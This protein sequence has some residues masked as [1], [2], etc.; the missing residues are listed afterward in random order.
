MKKRL[1]FLSMLLMLVTAAMTLCLTAC[2]EKSDN[3]EP[4]SPTP[5]VP[6]G[7]KFTIAPTGGT[8][9]AGTLKMEIPSGTFTGG[10]DVYVDEVSARS[11]RGEDEV[12]QFYK[13]TMR[14][15]TGKPVKVSIACSNTDDD[16]MFV[17]RSKAYSISGG[18]TSEADM[19]LDFTYSNGVYTAEIP[20][21]HNNQDDSAMGTITFGLAHSAS[22]KPA[23]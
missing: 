3:E 7:D 9:E 13:I 20:A 17:A 8:V 22:A 18:L 19:Q 12:S 4:V 21:F 1:S 15:N 10:A 2:S 5:Q 14:A 6:T 11:V 16:I 23:A